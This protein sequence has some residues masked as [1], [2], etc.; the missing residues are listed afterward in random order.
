[1]TRKANLLLLLIATTTFAYG[2][3]E[4]EKLVRKSFDNYKSAI[5]NDK[6]DEAV[7]YVDSKTIRYYGDILDLVKNADSTQVTSL[8]LLDKLMVFSIRHRTAKRDILSFDGKGLLV[9]AI[10]SGMVGKN[11]VA[12]NGIGEVIIDK[13]FAKGEFISLGEKAPFYFHFHKE[14]GQWKLDLTALFSVSGAAL[15]RMV[16]ESGHEE[17]EFIFSMLE[18]ITGKK[19]GREIWEKVQ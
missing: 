7:K 8:S 15:E 6:G 19:P 1:M 16:Q 9:Y 5:L 17:N 12:N 4:E 18:L 2:Q 10:K 13:D 3:R 14:E 11:S